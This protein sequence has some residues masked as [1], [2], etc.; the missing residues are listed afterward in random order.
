MV[1][2]ALGKKN[3]SQQSTLS[4]AASAVSTI[5]AYQF[6]Y[7]RAKCQQGIDN[8]NALLPQAQESLTAIRSGYNNALNH[9]DEAGEEDYNKQLDNLHKSVETITTR[10]AKLKSC[11]DSIN[12]KLTFS[13]TELGEL[14]SY[15]DTSTILPS[16]L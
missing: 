5:N 16:G 4:T 13:P 12:Q 8:Y 15:I 14:N 1:V 11:I 3:T 7:M 6:D 9:A 2:L 10:I